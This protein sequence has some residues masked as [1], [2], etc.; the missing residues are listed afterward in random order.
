MEEVKE[1]VSEGERGGMEK[2]G[3]GEKGCWYEN[4]IFKQVYRSLSSKI[5]AEARSRSHKDFLTKIL[6]A[7]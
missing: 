3:G 7:M 2:S 1:W 4:N 6:G 5:H